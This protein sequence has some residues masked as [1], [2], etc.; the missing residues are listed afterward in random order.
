MINYIVFKL[1][2]MFN[3]KK[4][5]FICSIIT[6]LKKKIREKFFLLKNFQFCIDNKIGKN[7]WSLDKLKLINN[8]T[9]DFYN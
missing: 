7:A 8:Q 1:V 5:K 2:R 9:Y 6:R 4:I 3:K